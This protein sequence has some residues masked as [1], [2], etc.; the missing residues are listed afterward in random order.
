MTAETTNT[1]VNMY[2]CVTFMIM[3]INKPRKD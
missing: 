3:N 2:A 1:T